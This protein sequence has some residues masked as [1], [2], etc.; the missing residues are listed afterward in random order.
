MHLSEVVLCLSGSTLFLSSRWQMTSKEINEIKFSMRERASQ[1]EIWGIILWTNGNKEGRMIFKVQKKW[2]EGELSDVQENCKKT[3]GL[4]CY[5]GLQKKE[6]LMTSG[7]ISER[8]DSYICKEKHFILLTPSKLIS[9]IC[10]TNR[11][12]NLWD[13]LKISCYY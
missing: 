2:H 3:C 12:L 10:I 7:N 1:G 13:I 5:L 9:I 4:W 8:S 6:D 11:S